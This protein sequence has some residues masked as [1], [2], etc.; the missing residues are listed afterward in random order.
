MILPNVISYFD[1]QTINNEN[2]KKFLNL[3]VEYLV[4]HKKIINS[5]LVEDLKTG[6]S[7]LN[8]VEKFSQ[9]KDLSQLTR[10]FSEKKF[11]GLKLY[12][13][14]E[15]FLSQNAQFYLESKENHNELILAETLLLIPIVFP[16]SKHL[17]ELVDRINDQLVRNLNR[18]SSDQNW[19]KFESESFLLSLSHWTYTISNRCESV[20][21]RVKH[22]VELIS[23]VGE[24]GKTMNN[25]FRALNYSIVLS[26]DKRNLRPI[27][28]DV[29]TVVKSHL[30]SPYHEIRLNSLNLLDYYFQPEM[31]AIERIKLDDDE[32][33]NLFEICT[34]AEMTRASLEEYRRK[35]FYIQRLDTNVCSKYFQV[36]QLKDVNFVVIENRN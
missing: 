36:E 10:L 15:K 29:I 21:T 16:T 25:L 12:S 13:S 5:E 33:L 24:H 11:T 23:K 6:Q 22:L 3:T 27:L 35:L 1:A 9:V 20:E 31:E 19:E 34:K 18:L 32:E 2:N 28:K 7:A 17:N 8:F 26:N 14:L 4:R 30:S